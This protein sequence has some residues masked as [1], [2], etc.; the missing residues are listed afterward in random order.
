[1]SRFEKQFI[2]NKAEDIEDAYNRNKWYENDD[3]CD[4]NLEN[5]D[6]ENDTRNKETFEYD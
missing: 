4:D 1:M 2:K 5:S 6:D 3:V